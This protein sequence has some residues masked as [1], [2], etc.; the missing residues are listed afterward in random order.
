MLFFPQIADPDVPPSHRTF[1]TLCHYI[2]VKPDTARAK[3]PKWIDKHLKWIKRVTAKLLGIKNRSFEDFKDEWL[4]GSFPLDEA[5][6]LIVCRAY[7]IHA[8]VFFNNSYWTTNST[9][10][11]NEVNVFLVYQG[12]LVFEDT[13]RM[14]TEEYNAR[15][16][17]L[18]KLERYY[19]DVTAK[20]HLHALKKRAEY[21]RELRSGRKR[22]INCIE[23]DED[24]T[25][26]AKKSKNQNIMPKEDF[27][28]ESLMHESDEEQKQQDDKNKPDESTK[29]NSETEGSAQSGSEEASDNE[30]NKPDESTK[31]NSETEGS[32]Q[33]GS[34]EASD[35]ENNK[36]DI[37]TKEDGE[38]N[39]SDDDETHNI[40]D[41][42]D[43]DKSTDEYEKESM[44]GMPQEVQDDY[45][46]RRLRS[47]GN[48]IVGSV[49][50]INRPRRKAV[51]IKR[52]RVYC[53]HPKCKKNYGTQCA[54]KRHQRNNHNNNARFFCGESE[55]NGRACTKS[56]PNQQQLDQHIRGI[57]GDGFIAY[58][59]KKFT[60]PKE[61][62]NHQFEC[63]RCDKVLK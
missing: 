18:K 26:A 16:P 24:E 41:N 12:N 15:K 14:T 45:N 8:S 47:H 46:Q 40:S 11:L 39:V 37:S 36:Q 50:E 7:K 55:R 17:Q 23:S 1:N 22:S 63:R 57:H 53:N 21:E 20:N 49:K 3:L 48:V 32:A 4:H 58:C 42:S 29:E 43:Y 30:E 38:S 27:D 19:D 31:E 10:D 56:Y 52:G 59:G 44:D 60:W 5:G 2:G 61:R 9:G 35:N 34:E 6:I 33:S 51:K 28:L 25:P 13:R 62:F 54:M